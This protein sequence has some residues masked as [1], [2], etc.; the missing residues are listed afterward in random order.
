MLPGAT[1]PLALLAANEPSKP[2]PTPGSGSE[3]E[4][5][6]VLQDPLEHPFFSWPRTLIRYQMTLDPSV[7]RRRWVL[8][9]PETGEIVPIQ[10]SEGSPAADGTPRGYLHFFSDLPSGGRRE[11]V[12][13]AARGPTPSTPSPRVRERREGNSIVLDAGPVQVRIPASRNGVVGAAPG[14]IL[15]IARGGRWFGGSTLAFR[16][17]HVSRLTARRVAEGPLFIA[18]ELTYETTRGSRYIARIQC[19]AGVEFI[20]FEE[21]MEGVRPGAHGEFR[22]VWS[23][24]GLT[25]R[26]APNHPFPLPDAVAG[27]EDYPWE[28]ID[29]V[30]AL[31]PQ[32]LPE[33]RLPFSLGVYERAPGNFRTATFANFWNERS[34]DALGL[35]IHDVGAWCDHEYAYEVESPS[36]QVSF[37]AVDGGFHWRWP[38]VRGRRAVCLAFYDHAKDKEAMRQLEQAHRGVVHDGRLHSV[39]L[40]CTSHVLFLQNRHGTLDLNRVKDWVLEYPEGGAHPAPGPSRG[41]DVDPEELERRVMT[42]PFTCTLPVTGTRQMA[43]HGPIP[44]RSIVNFSPVPSRQVAGWVDD[45][46]QSRDRMTVRQ[47]RR[48]TAMLLLLGHVLG[49]DEFMPVVH[50]L[51]G[52]PNFL[53]DVKA[54]PAAMAFLFP[55]HP[56]ASVWA[57][58]WEKCVELNTRYNTRPAVR[59]WSARGGRWTE[60]LG[61]YVWAFLGP[62]LRTSHLLR[63]YDGRERFLSPQL[64]DLADWLVNA[65]SAPFSGESE[66]GFKNLNATDHGREWGVVPPRG[67]PRRVHPPQGAHSEQRF[68]P[69]ML[70]ALGSRLQCYAPL[71]A[72]HAMWAA[73]P[74]DPDAEEAPGSKGPADPMYQVADNRGTNPRL[75]SCKFTGYGIVLRAGVGE[76]DELSIH[77]QQ[78]DEGPNYRWGRAGEGGSGILYFY[79]GGKSYSHTGPEDVGDRDDQDTDFCTTFGV[80]KNGQFRTIGMNVLSRPLYDFGPAQYAEIVPRDGPSS[81]ATPELVS[82]SVL[83]AGREY[84]VLYDAVAHQALTHRLTWFVR[85][86]GEFPEIQLLRG[87]QGHRE[88]QRTDVTTAS[89]VGVWFDGLGDSLAVVS[90]RKDVRAE[91][92]A[93]GCRVTLPGF[94]DLVFRNPEPV[95]FTEGGLVFEG[96]AGF[97]RIAAHK[98]EFSM[99]HGRR[100]GGLGFEFVAEDP[101]FGLAG[102]LQHE[103]PVAGEYLAPKPLVLRVILP[104]ESSARDFYVDGDRVPGK[105]GGGAMLYAIPA[106]RHRW[107]LTHDLPVPIA[108]RIVRTETLA[109]GARVIAGPVAA[110]TRYLLE[111]STDGGAHWVECDERPTPELFVSRLTPGEKIHVRV[112][113]KNELHASPPG[114]DYPVYGSNQAPPPPDGLR[115]DLSGGAAA[116]TWGEVLGVSAYRLYARLKSEERYRLVYAGLERVF[117]DSRAFIRACDPTPAGAVSLPP[118]R[119]IEYRVAAVNGIGEGA[120]SPPADTNPASWRNW[121][122]KRREPFRRV[123]SVP[124]DAVTSDGEGSRYYPD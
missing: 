71:A 111:A 43:G 47:R 16:E 116:V 24:L 44:G 68:A 89:T 5:R 76:I 33:G 92:T 67:G 57:G 79:A 110:A 112:V 18:Y 93:F 6:F 25:H 75:R 22:S 80:F 63:R 100:I 62:S 13:A 61:T 26:Q 90:H 31:K 29:G 84:F 95:R 30:F 40:T 78:L 56:M 41:G 39:P 81:V 36:L 69:R 96:T 14:P 97:F 15:Q 119:M 66:A 94:T 49:G 35:F 8:R 114:D 98:T 85:K 115:V 65:L 121:D 55:E 59:A 122:P 102:I 54:V 28:R 118:S 88:T 27:Y 117:I 1:A 23:D 11:F 32:P 38:V 12:L 10:W 123:T 74:T 46:N 113:A 9:R 108:P 64:A 82:R 34:S 103:G 91:P 83:L 70:W 101:D 51:S 99:F 86:G 77:L 109:G 20:R 45:F 42:S 107:E 53:A 87:A 7:D 48:L 52:H 58:M 17:D 50:M 73:R 106:G 60:N 105:P 19:E 72:E 2:S 3:G 124:S 21:N 120:L 37:H 4:I 104:S